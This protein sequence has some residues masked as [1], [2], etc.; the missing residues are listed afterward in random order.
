VSER[1]IVAYVLQYSGEEFIGK[2]VLTNRT[3]RNKQCWSNLNK[4]P[5]N[6]FD[7]V[8]CGP[9]HHHHPFIEM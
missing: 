6:R 8:K 3:S 5:A 4:N 2:K 7:L 9:H 1:V